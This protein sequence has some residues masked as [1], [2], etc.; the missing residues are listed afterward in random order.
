MKITVNEHRQIQ[1]EKVYNS[2]IL[3]SDSGEEIA[4]CMRDSGFEFNYQDQ[5]YSAQQGVVKKDLST[6][7]SVDKETSTICNTFN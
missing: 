1:L 4:I 5:W 6:P 2:I 3:K 7:T